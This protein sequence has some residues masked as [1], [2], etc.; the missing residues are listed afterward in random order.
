[1]I[2]CYKE[3]NV[4]KILQVMRARQR[5]DIQM[6]LPALQDLDNM[7][8]V[9]YAFIIIHFADYLSFERLIFNKTTDVQ[10]GEFFV[11]IKITRSSLIL[12]LLLRKREID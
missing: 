10:K 2:T 11:T 12:I 1:M 5:I 4:L 7:L 3:S 8:M 6:N 9:R